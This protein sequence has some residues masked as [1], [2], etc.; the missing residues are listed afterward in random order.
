MPQFDLNLPKNPT[1]QTK[2]NFAHT[3]TLIPAK[4]AVTESD[5][6]TKQ[7]KSLDK[8]FISIRRTPN[9]AYS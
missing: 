6:K 5:I 3:L 7:K 8:H 2:A 1:T 9:E 4:K